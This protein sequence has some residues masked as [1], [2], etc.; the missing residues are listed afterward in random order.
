M[1]S[2]SL[3]GARVLLVE[4]ETMIAMDVEELCRDHG[5]ADV[6]I[7]S[8]L[9]DAE[10]TELAGFDG[11]IVDLKLRDE[12]TIGIAQRLAEARV[13]F[14]F[15][16]GYVTAPEIGEAFPDVPV[17]AKPYDGNALI[18]TLANVMRRKSRPG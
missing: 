2:S 4:D 6:V 12:P 8:R 1:V 18:A 7:V 15:A 17:I 14:I 11:A 3:A 10:R 5:A 16:T 13:P 9:D